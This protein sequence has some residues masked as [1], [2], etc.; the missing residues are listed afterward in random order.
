MK[1]V[2]LGSVYGDKIELADELPA[3][4]EIVLTDMTRYDPQNMN[5]QKK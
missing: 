5:I 1:T 4:T 2:T 3:G